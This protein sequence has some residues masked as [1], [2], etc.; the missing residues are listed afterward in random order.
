MPGTTI[1]LELLEFPDIPGTTTRLRLLMYPSLT[2]PDT[3]KRLGTT[4]VFWQDYPFI[5][6]ICI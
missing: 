3:I 5:P 6:G 2:I 4:C 1:R